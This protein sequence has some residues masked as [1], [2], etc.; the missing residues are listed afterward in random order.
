MMPYPK[1][2]ITTYIELDSIIKKTNQF[3]LIEFFDKN[4]GINIIMDPV[5]KKVFSVSTAEFSHYKVEV[6]QS[7]SLCNYYHIY[8]V[9]QYLIIY[10][11]TILKRISGIMPIGEMLAHFNDAISLSRKLSS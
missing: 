11:G 4:N 6:N 5:I 7:P 10:N 3:L 8:S 2:I 9:P 1:T